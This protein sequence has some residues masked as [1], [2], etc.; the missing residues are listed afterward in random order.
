MKW[1]TLE[2]FVFNSQVF[3]G[4][5]FMLCG[6]YFK[7]FSIWNQSKPDIIHED[8]D[9]KMTFI[10]NIFYKRK[11]A[12]FMHYM[13]FEAYNWILHSSFLTLDVLMLYIHYS[14]KATQGKDKVAD[15]R[16]VIGLYVMIVV[17]LCALIGYSYQLSH[18]HT[19]DKD[20]DEL[21]NILPTRMTWW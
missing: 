15:D 19:K 4:I 20:S 12:D 21:Y 1:F 6:Y 16:F 3:G 11:S 17:H 10:P 5:L 13:K 14:I 9:G 7:F 8:A 2:T 18:E